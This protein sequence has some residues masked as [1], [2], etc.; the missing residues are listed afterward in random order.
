MYPTT[1][2]RRPVSNITDSIRN[3]MFLADRGGVTDAI[4]S[5]RSMLPTHG[6]NAQLHEAIGLLQ[7]RIGALDQA[8]FHFDKARHLEPT[9]SDMHSNYATAINMQGKPADAVEP[10][11]KAVSLD[12]KSFPAQLGL[13]SA[14]IGVRDFEP[15]IEAARAATKIASMRPEGWV[16]LSIALSR[17]GQGAEAIKVLEEAIGLMPSEILLHTNLAAALNYRPEATPQHVFEAHVNLGRVLANAYGGG[18]RSFNND[19]NPDRPLRIAYVSADFK[20]HPVASFIAPVLAAHD[21]VN[22]RPYCYSTVQNPDATTERLRALAPEWRDVGRFPDQAIIQQI[23]ADRID[24]LVDLGGH[25]A[26]SRIGVFAGR[27]APVQATWLGYAN[28]TGL[29]TIGYRIV[30]NTTDPDGSEALSTEK[31]SRIDGCFVCF[32]PSAV[33]PEVAP[34]PSSER[35]QPFT[36]GSFN[37]PQKVVETVIEAWAAILRSKAGSRLLLKDAGF[38]DA[39]TVERIRSRFAGLGITADRVEFMTR[40][41]S[42]REHLATYSRVDLALDTFPYNGTSTTCEALDMGV[43]VVTLRGQTHAGRVGASILKCAGLEGTTANSTEDYIRIATQ[44]SADTDR[45]ASLRTG[46]R[47]RTRNSPL[48]DGPAFTRKL[49]AAYR[50]MWK[51]WGSNLMYMG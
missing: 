34:L 3:A 40:I 45:L 51:G 46:L 47:A 29:K 38:D 8:A 41:E 35:G 17:S 42:E 36:F 15:A 24:I 1:E 18:I 23:G 13:S 5:L 50:E 6:Q 30:D 44:F 26:G 25:T 4:S 14:L 43:P 7:F 37:N 16:N 39:A 10:F 2:R 33:A 28:T 19:P 32:Q 27:G 20:D 31:L 22:Y 12:A 9:R 21:R 48:C 11:R 49:E